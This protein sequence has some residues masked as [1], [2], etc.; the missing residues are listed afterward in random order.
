MEGLQLME[1]KMDTGLG[2]ETVTDALKLD[3][4][5]DAEFESLLLITSFPVFTSFDLPLKS[6]GYFRAHLDLA[7]DFH[8]IRSC[9]S[10]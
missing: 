4:L 1:L 7:G 2:F 3:P 8:L 9:A 6:D 5:T 10:S